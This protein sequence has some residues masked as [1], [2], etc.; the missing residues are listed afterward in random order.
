VHVADALAAQT[1]AVFGAR[2]SWEII[3][4]TMVVLAVVLHFGGKKRQAQ[5]QAQM[6]EL[7]LTSGLVPDATNPGFPVGVFDLIP[8]R[9]A[10]SNMVRDRVRPNE[11]FGFVASFVVGEHQINRTIGAAWVPSRHA[12]LTLRRAGAFGRFNGRDIKIGDEEFDRRWTVLCD[13]P[14]FAMAVL[15][16]LVQAWL[17][18]FDDSLTAPQFEVVG[19]DVIASTEI[20]HITRLPE[21]LE[22]A[23]TFGRH[24]E[25]TTRRV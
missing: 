9:S 13:E 20:E 16:T 22:L 23:E 18:T 8:K 3:V 6:V 17:M 1:L 14:E 21:L 10:F 4:P 11:R 19:H 24:L 5:R 12:H 15:T 2:G 25:A 7:T